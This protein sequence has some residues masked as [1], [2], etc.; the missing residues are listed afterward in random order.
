MCGSDFLPGITSFSHLGFNEILSIYRGSNVELIKE[1][2][3]DLKALFI[4]MDIVLH[5]SLT[6]MPVD[7]YNDKY[8][9]TNEIDDRK[10]MVAQYLQGLQWMVEY[11]YRASFAIFYTLIC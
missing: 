11:I 10:K 5:S 6:G 4:F 9:E 1:E 3:L 2:R 7:V 8:F